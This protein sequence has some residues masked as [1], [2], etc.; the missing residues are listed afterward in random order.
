MKISRENIEEMKIY[1]IIIYF[2][3]LDWELIVSK[4]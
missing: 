4:I 3:E 1:F 2:Y